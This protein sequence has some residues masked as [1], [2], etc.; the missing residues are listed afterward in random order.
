MDNF[1]YS[2]TSSLELLQSKLAG[3]GDSFILHL[4]NLFLAIIIA[5]MAYLFVGFV[6]KWSSKLLNKF[7]DNVRI[8]RLGSSL[9]VAILGVFTLFIILGLFNLSGT[10]N[11]ILATAGVL[12]LAVGLALQDPLTN[13][14]SG[15]MMS[16]RDMYAIGDLVETNNFFGTIREINLRT[17]CLL[18]PTGEEVLIP[19]KMVI[20]HPL[21]NYSK[22][23]YRRI[24]LNCGVS[25][26]E[27]LKK[28]QS[29][30]LQALEGSEI[31]LHNRPVDLVYTSFG[32]SSINF[33]I[34]Y[35]IKSDSQS[36][37]LLKLSEGIVVLKESFDKHQITI[38][39]PIR[40]LD[41]G[42]KGGMGLDDL[43]ISFNGNKEIINN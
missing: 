22:N 5:V 24:D 19:N 11:K 23:G 12:G 25:Y 32:D 10:I 33:K 14:F 21:K 38:P 35:W 34:R 20:Q 16:V 8:V 18:L 2:F 36:D 37:Y 27:D 29:I 7:T 31:P 28:V 15:V 41:F 6:R 1:A 4:P 13:L 26:G 40:T 39:F 17:T 30:A 9:S 43:N 3:W 42:I